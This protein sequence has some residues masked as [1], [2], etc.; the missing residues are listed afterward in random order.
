M[1]HS[2]RVRAAAD[3]PPSEATRAITFYGCQPDEAAVLRD[4]ATRLGVAPTII[5]APLSEANLELALGSRCLSISHKAKV[6]NLTLQTLGRA[7]LRYI[8]TRSI[9]YDHLDVGYASRVGITVENVSYSPDSVAD[10]TLM[11]M[12]MAVRGARSSI[13][14]VEV[15][16]YRLSQARGRELRDL[17]VGVI[18]TGRIGTAVIERLRAFGCRILTYDASGSAHVALDELL[19]ESDIVSLHIP[20]TP[21]THHLLDRSRI[22]QLKSDAVVVNTG[23]G[24]LI[25]TEALLAALESG[26]VGGAALDVVEGE[27]GIFYTDCRDRPLPHTM[28]GRLHALPNVIITPHTAYYTHRALHDTMENSLVGCLTFESGHHGD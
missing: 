23:R 21:R 19:R 2:T 24:P 9:G 14:R 13:R 28:L 15:H 11:L 16:D 6:S 17:T 10:Y 22:G 1:S 27:E 3:R 4:L 12:L 26:R 18:G 5:E 25:D 20:L 7:G 8:S